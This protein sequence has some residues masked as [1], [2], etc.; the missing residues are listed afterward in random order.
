MSPILAGEVL[1]T[2][3]MVRNQRLVRRSYLTFG[4]LVK[5]RPP[6]GNGD[7]IDAKKTSVSALT[8]P[9][10][11]PVA[12]LKVRTRPLTWTTNC[13]GPAAPIVS[14]GKAPVSASVAPVKFGVDTVCG[15]NGLIACFVP[16]A[17]LTLLP[18][19]GWPLII[20]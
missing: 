20:A 18:N 8:T 4:S 13:V 2:S 19:T 14:G 3:M 5:L 16:V 12:L 10:A 15:A 6:T 7:M 17:P 11:T 1:G 9:S